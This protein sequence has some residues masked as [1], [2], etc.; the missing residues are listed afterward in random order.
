METSYLSNLAISVEKEGPPQIVKASFPLR[1]GK[2]SEIRTAEYEFRF[3]LNGEIKFIRGLNTNWPH[4]AEQL[5]RTDGNDWVYYSI[6]DKSGEKGIISWLGEYYLPCLPYPSNSI[7]EISYYA[8]P[9]IMNA[10]AAWSQLF[11]SLYESKKDRLHAKVQELISCVIDNHDG[12]LFKRSQRLNEITGGRVSVL[13]PDT[14]HVDYEIIPLIIADGCLYHCNFCCV[15]SDRKFQIRSRLDILEQIEKLKEYYGRN[16]ENYNGLFLGNHDALQAGADLIFDSASEAY[17][18]FGFGDQGR[19]VPK[20]F[21]FGSVHSMLKSPASV[22]EKLSQLPF[23]TFINVGLETYDQTT[24]AKLGKPLKRSDVYATFMK[25]LDINATYENIEVTANFVIGKGLSTQH[26]ESLKKLL[27]TAAAT[28]KRKG[29]I[30]LSPL[31]DSPKKRELLPMINELQKDSN[32][33][34]YV[35]LIQRL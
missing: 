24:L 5:K 33:P 19:V 32:L 8:N 11:G 18:A 13:P 23:Y 10:F 21:L 14:R 4:P 28:S 12:V 30:Y 22:F 1:Y 34:V 35:Y 3:N 9:A 25:M 26:Y 16:I 6:G 29:T 15:K 27:Q 31:Q 2:Y 7:W 20:L 17:D